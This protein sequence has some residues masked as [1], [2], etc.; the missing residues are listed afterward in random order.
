LVSSPLST[1]LRLKR[2]FRVLE[3]RY[4]WNSEP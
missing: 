1:L 4:L 3:Q 2:S